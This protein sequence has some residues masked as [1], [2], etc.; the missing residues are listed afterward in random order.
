MVFYYCTCTELNE[1]KRAESAGRTPFRE[2]KIDED[3]VCV[4]CGYYAVAYFDRIDP[5]RVKLYDKL[6]NTGTPPPLNHKGGLSIECSINKKRR[7]DRESKGK[8]TN[9]NMGV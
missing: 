7:D 2:V 9:G 5:N 6:Y 1:Q 8:N 3:G 4:N